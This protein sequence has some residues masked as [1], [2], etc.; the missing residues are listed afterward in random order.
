MRN[1]HNYDTKDCYLDTEKYSFV[2]ISP[3]EF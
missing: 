2:I 1:W 3:S